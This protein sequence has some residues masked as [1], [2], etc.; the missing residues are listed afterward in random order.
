MRQG[1]LVD[2]ASWIVTEEGVQ[3]VRVDSAA[4]PFAREGIIQQLADRID[5]AKLQDQWDQLRPDQLPNS[6]MQQGQPYHVS[7]LALAYCSVVMVL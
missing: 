2:G 4:L 5:A 6:L 7:T 1:C 3:A